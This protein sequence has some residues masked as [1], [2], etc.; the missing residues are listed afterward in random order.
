[1]VVRATAAVKEINLKKAVA[2]IKWKN[3]AENDEVA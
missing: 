3:E 1:M 2:S